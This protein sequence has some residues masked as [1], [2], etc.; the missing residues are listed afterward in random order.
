MT[1]FFSNRIFQASLAALVI[2][3]GFYAFNNTQNDEEEPVAT[4]DENTDAATNV[5][6]KN[7]VGEVNTE[8]NTIE[9]TVETDAI[10]ENAVQQDVV[11]KDEADSIE[12]QNAQN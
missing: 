8:V 3:F 4:Q 2:G 7:A 12:S 11:L 1:K 10:I 6:T 5:E 9:T